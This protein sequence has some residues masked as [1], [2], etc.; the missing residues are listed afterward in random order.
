MSPMMIHMK[1]Q[2]IVSKE[3]S[4]LSAAVVIW[5]MLL[6]LNEATR[7]SIFIVP[8]SKQNL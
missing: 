7:I 6:G 4:K 1:C 5:I 8:N 3:K 2:A